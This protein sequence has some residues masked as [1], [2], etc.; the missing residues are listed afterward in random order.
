MQK[1]SQKHLKWIKSLHLKKN[2]D[3]EHSFIVEGIKI[4]DEVLENYEHRIQYVVCLN[5]Y[6][7]QLPKNLESVIL[8]AS[9]NE[10]SRISTLKT[11]NSILIVLKKDHQISFNSSEKVI[12]LDDIQDPG[13]MGTLIRT[14]DWFGISQFVCSKKT[15]DLFNAKALQ[16]TMGSF[17]RVKIWYVELES[18]IKEHNLNIGG[19]LLDGTTFENEDLSQ[20]NA[21][22]LGNESRG[23]SDTMRAHVNMPIRIDGKGSAESLNV[24][25]A[26][27]I[28]MQHWSK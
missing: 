28:F 25:I 4:C 15:A 18:F 5:D 17:L 20:M 8:T 22:L 10:L 11:P 7:E 14:A 26:G 12:L 1:I 21:L 9:A 27:A 13:N 16:S 19:A 6:S 23:I 24:A 3:K 2:R